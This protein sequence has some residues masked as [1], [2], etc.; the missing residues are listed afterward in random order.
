MAKGEA[1]K[2]N[3]LIDTQYRNDQAYNQMETEYQRGQRN[4]AEVRR[5]EMYQPTFQGYRDMAESGGVTDAD[6]ERMRGILS[7]LGKF[8][9]N[10]MD[11]YGGGGGGG[12]YISPN[13]ESMQYNPNQWNEMEGLYRDSIAG[14]SYNQDLLRSGRPYVEGLAKTGG[15]DPAFLQSIGRN[16]SMLD[17]IATS[18]GVDSNAINR[19]RGGGV[20][21]EFANTGGYSDYDR[22]NIRSRATSGIPA[23]YDALKRDAA[24]ASRIGN[25]TMG[26]AAMASRNA[27]NAS[28]DIAEANRNAE[29][30]IMERVNQ[31]RQWGAGNLSQSEA[32]LANLQSQNRLAALTQSTGTQRGMQEFMSSMGLDA[33]KWLSESELPIQEAL[34]KERQYGIGGLDE[35]AQRRIAE[36]EKAMA[37]RNAAAQASANAYNSG[38]DRSRAD[39]LAAAEGQ[40]KRQKE[41]AGMGIDLESYF[42][43]S[44]NENKFGGLEGLSN[45]YTSTP[46]EVGMREDIIGRNRQVEMGGAQDSLGLRAQYNPNIS[47]WDRAT[48]LIGAGS[49]IA[50]AF[51]GG[52][53]DDRYTNQRVPMNQYRQQGGYYTGGVPQYRP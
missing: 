17:D 32:G 50:G 12:G 46:G 18:G 40:W 37:Q 6:R 33:G 24:Q 31:G 52:F 47:T 14:K 5:N 23:Y 42:L 39:S 19:I 20:F 28:R 49:G 27:R 43:D 2:T 4:E 1:K 8:D 38:I 11:A 25:T 36:Q 45:L 21:D 9:Q 41:L 35:I 30:D 51:M 44:S 10:I 7:G 34:V 26:S 53:G 13:L 48:Q 22:A 29:I 16:V 15:Y 3:Q